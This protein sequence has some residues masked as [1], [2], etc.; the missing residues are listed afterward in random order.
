VASGKAPIIGA[1]LS[2]N[3]IDPKDWSLRRVRNQEQGSRTSTVVRD[4][5]R[6][7]VELSSY[8]PN[9]F[10]RHFSESM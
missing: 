6:S 4:P 8:F 1:R 7:V 5:L 2:G 10:S 3:R 9:R